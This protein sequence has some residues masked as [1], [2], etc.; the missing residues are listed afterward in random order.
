[1]HINHFFIADLIKEIHRKQVK[2]PLL[3]EQQFVIRTIVDAMFERTQSF[4]K[5]LLAA[6][7]FFF[8]LPFL[9]QSFLVGMTWR[10]IV[11]HALCCTSSLFF[12]AI[13]LIMI[14]D[15]KWHYFMD[16]TS[17]MDFCSYILYWIYLGL[18]VEAHK[19]VSSLAAAGQAAQLSNENALNDL[20]EYN[21]SKIVSNQFILVMMKVLV[22]LCAFVKL[23][24]YLRVYEEFG[25][26]NKLLYE[27]I[28][29]V[30]IFAFFFYGWIFMFSLLFQILGM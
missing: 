23:Q 2:M 20:Q 12:F 17:V 25:L 29:E 30:K 14:Y 16:L 3:M 22:L 24:L 5:R 18:I 19:G 27:A 28:L 10:F 1:M 7:F 4:Q 15:D 26:L 13:E 6:Y 9:I 11:C 8:F 21:L